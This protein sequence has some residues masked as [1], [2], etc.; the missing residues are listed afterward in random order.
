MISINNKIKANIEKNIL[1]EVDKDN[2]FQWKK[3]YLLCMMNA[4]F[5]LLLLFV[6]TPVHCLDLKAHPIFVLVD[7]GGIIGLVFSIV[8]IKRGDA[9]WAGLL[10]VFTYM[11]I[12]FLDNVIGDWISPD[13]VTATRFFETL[14]MIS[15]LFILI[16]IYSINRWQIILGAVFSILI[17]LGHFYVLRNMIKVDIPYQDLLYVLMP[18]TMGIIAIMNLHLV[19]DSLDESNKLFED[20]FHQLVESLPAGVAIYQNE[21]FV[22]V[23]RAALSMLRAETPDSRIGMHV[24][25]TVHPESREIVMDR[26][27]K[28]AAGIEVP[29]VDERI[30]RC[31]GTDF[32]A[33]ISSSSVEYEHRPAGQV[34]FHDVSWRYEAAETIARQEQLLR[35]I[36]DVVPAFITV[37]GAKDLRYQFVNSAYEKSFGKP[38]AEIEGAYMKD[39]LGDDTFAFALPY[40]EKA[41]QGIACSYENMFD[42]LDRKMWGKVM[43]TPGFSP[44]GEVETLIVLSVDITEQKEIEETIRKREVK[45]EVVNEKLEELSHIDGLTQI[46]NRSYFDVIL[47]KI[48]KKT[49]RMQNQLSIIM[50]D[51]DYFKK[52]NDCY[53]HQQGDVCLAAIAKVL[54][55][56]LN[57]KNDVLARYGGEEFIVLVC[58]NQEEALKI[59]ENMRLSVQKLGMEHKLSDKLIVSISLGVAT[60]IPASEITSYDLIKAADE[61]LY[62]SKNNGR[63]MVSIKEV[64]K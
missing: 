22:Y 30:L 35:T 21:R 61:A 40:I 54:K 53:G 11:L 13:H 58:T 16:I 8:L 64:N 3:A 36:I 18:I 17:V 26:I 20:S 43:Y 63:D 9:A 42:L 48:W 59:A 29:T 23:N 60:V 14:V 27:G 52:Y 34:L 51:I 31:D 25:D 50:M 62:E 39:I 24:L 56:Q 7:I 47:K 46:Y 38:R 5:L 41:R 6:I 37:I 2:Y 28:I 49:F 10:T 4:Y 1:N 19:N 45:L 32:M 44:N 55:E 57:G 15:F 12:P 33:E